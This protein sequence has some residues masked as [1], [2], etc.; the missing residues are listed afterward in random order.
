MSKSDPH[1]VPSPKSRRDF[2][3]LSG[4]IVGASALT[5]M[6]APHGLSAADNSTIKLAVV[7]CGG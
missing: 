3:K 2:M 5:G 1:E 7:G 6:A 4:Q